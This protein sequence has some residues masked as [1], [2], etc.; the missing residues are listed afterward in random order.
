MEPQLLW[1]SANTEKNYAVYMF[2]LFWKISG[3]M[4]TH[5]LL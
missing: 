5:N 1:L 4:L 3:F 2:S